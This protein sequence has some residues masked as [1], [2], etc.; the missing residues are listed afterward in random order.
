MRVERAKPIIVDHQKTMTVMMEKAWNTESGTRLQ[1][2]SHLG[3]V[4]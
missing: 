2:L 3:S 1:S 4:V